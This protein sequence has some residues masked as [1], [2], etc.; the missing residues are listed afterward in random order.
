MQYNIDLGNKFL[1]IYVRYTVVQPLVVVQF[2]SGKS[3]EKSATNEEKINLSYS[4]VEPFK[5][6]FLHCLVTDFGIIFLMTSSI[7]HNIPLYISESQKN[8]K[9]IFSLNGIAFVPINAQTS[10]T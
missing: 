7:N 8:I 1:L 5:I 6:L 10:I 3:K 9:H 4:T 2:M